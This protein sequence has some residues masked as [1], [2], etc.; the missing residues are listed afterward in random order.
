MRL[1]FL[2]FLILWFASGSAQLC[3]SSREFAVDNCTACPTLDQTR[4]DIKMAVCE[5]RAAGTGGGIAYA[6]VCLNFPDATSPPLVYYPHVEGNVTRCA[7]SWETAPQLY[8]ALLV[9]CACPPL[10]GAAHLMYIVVLS[11]MCSCKQQGCTKLNASALLMCMV[12]LC[13]LSIFLWTIAAQGEGDIGNAWVGFQ[14]VW[15]P[16]QIFVDVSLVLLYTSI[17]DM[18]F[19]GDDVA[20]W[21]I[22][23]LFITIYL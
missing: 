1:P 6:C 2:P 19:S 3:A 14:F 5:K 13:W 17:C 23:S 4:G 15:I 9:L 20:G 18:V 22:W 16:L 7:S 21:R 8:T 11:G 10:Y 12:A